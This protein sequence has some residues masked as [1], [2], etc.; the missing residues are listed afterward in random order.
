MAEF[1]ENTNICML[2]VLSFEQGQVLAC[3]RPNGEGRAENCAVGLAHEVLEVG[4]EKAVYRGT[5]E[6]N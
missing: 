6:G 5:V 4:H 3:G 1:A 2:Y